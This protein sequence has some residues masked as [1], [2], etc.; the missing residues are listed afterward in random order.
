LGEDEL[1]EFV[2]EDDFNAD[3]FL[4]QLQYKKE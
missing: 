4:Q 2:E 1:A 3:E